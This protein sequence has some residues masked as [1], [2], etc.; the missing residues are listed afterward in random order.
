M[1]I[2]FGIIASTAGSDA[3]IWIPVAAIWL[4]VIIHTTINWFRLKNRNKALLDLSAKHTEYTVLTKPGE[5]A[6]WF[7]ARLGVIDELHNVR[8]PEVTNVVSTPEWTYGDFEYTIYGSF[9]GED[10]R[11]TKVYYGV[12]TTTLPRSLP[13]I[14]FDSKKARRRQFRL[15]FSATQQH[16]LEGDFDKFFATYFPDGY[17]IDSMSFIAPDVMWAMRDA[18]DYDIEIY[19]NRLFLYGPLYN[20]DAQL[21]DMSTKILAIKKQLI[22]NVVN[23][24]DER[25][26]FA[27]GRKRV[28]FEG[29][30]LKVSPFWKRVS[31]IV[32][33]IALAIQFAIMLWGK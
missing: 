8:D 1:Y 4:F 13:H 6:V 5:K 16:S 2:F 18:R 31:A 19:G 21:A 11:R 27:E 9:K 20:P 32:A 24:R 30:K 23:Y 33:T 14:F 7:R 3:R 15:H 28:A 22:T 10:Y 12:M 29:A 26:A 25:L 17:T